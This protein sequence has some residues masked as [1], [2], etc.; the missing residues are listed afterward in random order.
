MGGGADDGRDRPRRRHKLGYRATGID[1]APSAIAA[2]QNSR[3][4][5]LGDGPAW[6]LMD[7][8]TDDIATLPDPAYAVVACRLVYRWLDDKPAFLDRVRHV[9]A[10]G[11]TF[12]V[13][14]EVAGR[15][16]ASDPRKHLGITAAEA[17][18]LTAGWSVVRTADLDVLRCYALRP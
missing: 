7:F 6:R 11:G 13:V 12:W 9:L 5:R 1:F 17:E 2:A 14:T 18:T 4:G 16:P 15:R 3:A 10:P 8:T